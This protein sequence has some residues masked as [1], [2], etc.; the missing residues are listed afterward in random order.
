MKSKPTACLR[1][2]NTGLMAFAGGLLLSATLAA[3]TTT[4]YVV[5]DNPG[6]EAPFTSWD[7]AAP[8]IQSAIDAAPAG[9]LV[10]VGDGL[11]DA[12][13][14]V[15]NEGEPSSATNRI[16][17]PDSLTVESAN[18]PESA[19]LQGGEGIRCA[20]L[21]GTA[22]L[23]GFGLTGAQGVGAVW[24][25][26]G[27][28]EVERCRIYGNTAPR[29]GGAQ[30]LTLIDCRIE[31][32]QA[33]LRGG[34]AYD[35]TLRDCVLVGNSAEHGG[36]A[37][38]SFL[39][40]SIVV[41]NVAAEAGGGTFLS[42]LRGC[43]VVANIAETGGGAADSDLTSTTV[44][45]NRANVAGGL[46]GGTALNSIVS[47][48]VRFGEDP[49]NWDNVA[50]QFSCATPLPPGDGNVDE[51]PLFVD[52][53]GGDFRPGD[54]SPCIDAGTNQD[55]M[56]TATD[57][58]GNPRIREGIV[59]MG[60]YE[61]QAVPVPDPHLQVLGVHG[62]P[63]AP[64]AQP[65]AE[66]GT[67]WV[68]RTG[69]NAART[70]VLTNAGNAAVVLS[71]MTV[72]GPGSAAFSVPGFPLSVEPAESQ[73]FLVV[74]SPELA[75]T[76]EATVE[77][78][79][80]ASN[81]PS[82][83]ALNLR[84]EG[85]LPAQRFVAAGNPAAAAPYTNWAT[86]AATIQ[87]AINLSLADDTIWVSNGIYAFGE[88]TSLG[89]MLYRVAITNPILVRSVNGPAA[90]F[91]QGSSG[92]R[93]A[94]LGPGATLAGF[95][96]TNGL[97]VG[98]IECADETA[99]VTNCVVTG[100][101][102]PVGGGVLGGTIRNSLLVG[103][104]ADNGGGAFNAILIDCDLIGNT[105][106]L[107]GGAF[108]SQLRGCRLEGNTATESG[109]GAFGSVLRESTLVDNVAQGEFGGGG[110]AAN[111]TLFSCLLVGNSAVYGGG[112]HGGFLNNCTLVG[113]SASAEGGGAYEGT[114]HNS[115][116]LFNAQ[117]L[118]EDNLHYSAS[119][120]FSC[121]TPLPPG[122]GNIDADPLFVDRDNG[123]FRLATNS[124]CINAG[125][126]LFWMDG[127]L[128]L[129]GNPRAVGPAADIGAYEHP[130]TPSGIPAAWLLDNDLPLD[131]S[132]DF[133][134]ADDDRFSNWS[135]WRAETD[136]RDPLS[137]LA[138]DRPAVARPPDGIG[139]IVRWQSVPGK[140]Y[141]LE[142]S[143]HL[144]DVPSFLP[145]AGAEAILGQAGFTTHTD[146]TATA[147]GPYLYR[148]LLP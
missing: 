127:E 66:A 27:T 97:N 47:G 51:D 39:W 58:D 6:A 24:S 65:D 11:Y 56:P 120:S 123:N 134:D 55:W 3:A 78:A 86:A 50:M 81:G 104:A 33:D 83:F 102:A 145:L 87:S 82:P 111:S 96:I 9:G 106:E 69:Q 122:P 60:A 141:A 144:P 109:G 143:T 142:R 121:A 132:E 62:L 28:P 70:F 117:G 112:S 32:N 57:L 113:N 45:D 4:H 72:T 20:A 59:D 126:T 64:D 137:R 125:E 7:T 34:G 100:N 80:S 89:D 118:V 146:R 124:P 44:A 16:V 94:Y 99:V 148:V 1:V 53:F 23:V 101:T 2:R 63:I 91:I 21:H 92:I 93:G 98:G 22:R 35:C 88:A 38:D 95:T 43:L 119:A 133:G 5:K 67:S 135:E 73:S 42:S 107:G 130:F 84:G 68:A 139:W 115:I 103:N 15:S 13:E 110:A 128:D 40:N 25:E 19:I 75:Q 71:G 52:P 49:D 77:I 105:A 85:V 138:L 26:D 114:L 74:F 46:S 90:T 147:T 30:G 129:G 37:S 131:G 36:G 10:L 12:G 116:V 17:I 76:Y 31:N 8:D 14:V 136:P 108:D 41:S 18:G 29:G 61:Y 48:N 54:G 79:H 140:L